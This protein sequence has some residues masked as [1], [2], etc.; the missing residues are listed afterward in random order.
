MIGAC[1]MASLGSCVQAHHGAIC[2]F[3]MAH[4][5]PATTVSSGGGRP[6]YGSGSWTHLPRSGVFL[7]LETAKKNGAPQHWEFPNPRENSRPGAHKLRQQP[8]ETPGAWTSR[9]LFLWRSVN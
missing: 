5:P 2:R 6:E 8:A 4:A 7:L 9:G 1:S 3:A